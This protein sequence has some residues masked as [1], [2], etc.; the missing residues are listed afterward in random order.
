[1]CLT[2][3]IWTIAE[4][5]CS[6]QF[7][8]KSKEHVESIFIPSKVFAVYPL[9][10][11]GTFFIIDENERHLKTNTSGFDFKEKRDY[12]PAFKIF[13]YVLKISVCSCAQNHGIFHMSGDEYTV[14]HILF[15]L[16]QDETVAK[17]K[18]EWTVKNSNDI[19]SWHRATFVSPEHVHVALNTSV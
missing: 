16:P 18:H 12:S 4:F 17:G 19:F 2:V 6:L 10:I 15:Y 1:M 7:P 5:E 14:T 9:K 11:M 8:V 13:P 3:M